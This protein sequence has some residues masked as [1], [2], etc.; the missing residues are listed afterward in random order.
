MQE[1]QA[2]DNEIVNMINV[3]ENDSEDSNGQEPAGEVIPPPV[4]SDSVEEQEDTPQ[5]SEEAQPAA[6]EA[7]P[8]VPVI[9]NPISVSDVILQNPDKYI[10]MILLNDSV[11]AS[12]ADVNLT[13]Y[14]VFID[15]NKNIPCVYDCQKLVLPTASVKNADGTWNI[16]SIEGRRS[17]FIIKCPNR[18]LVMSKNFIYDIDYDANGKI[19]SVKEYNRKHT[20]E[21]VTFEATNDYDTASFLTSS[22]LPKIVKC[23]KYKT[24]PEL[25]E[26][27]VNSY[28]T[29]DDI[30][31]LFKIVQLRM[32]IGC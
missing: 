29:V 16:T 5:T 7:A 23:G 28:N 1:E 25:Q 6:V 14:I 3:S 18:D 30:N 4:F 15:T 20:I 2:M 19:V 21:N 12:S 24:L 13:D 10:K 22:V 17:G 11:R 26:Q 27:V 8:T 31:G 32:K 9:E